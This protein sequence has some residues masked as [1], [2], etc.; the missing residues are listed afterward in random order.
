MLTPKRRFIAAY[1]EFAKVIA[2]VT[3]SNDFQT[4]AEAALLQLIS[5]LPATTDPVIAAACYHRVMGARQMLDQLLTVANPA[6][7]PKR[8]ASSSTLN[9]TA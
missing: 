4:A 1:P 7:L 3:A 2:E 5:E 8:E 9:Q 6:A